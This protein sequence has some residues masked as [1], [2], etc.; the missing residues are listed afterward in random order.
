MGSVKKV[1][2]YTLGCKLNFSETSTIT[3]SFINNGFQKVPF[4]AKADVYIINTCTVTQAADKKCRQIIRKAI[5]T[6][7]D[8]FIAVTGCYTQLN[9]NEIVNITGVDAILGNNEKFKILALLD[10][11][12]KVKKTQIITSKI[13][14]SIPFN[15]SYSLSDRTRSFLKIQDGCD[16][17]CSFCTIPL[18]RGKSRN[19]SISK[20]L[21]NVEIIANSGIKEIVLTGVNLGDFGKSTGESFLQLLKTIELVKGIERFRISSLEPNLISDEII[22]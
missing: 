4:S 20:T 9:P 2:F 10:N 19:Q 5:K 15:P 12:R 7:P 8:A 18:A 17:Y 6:N 22:E 14:K 13:K 1:A 3:R 21:E 11:F 16:Y